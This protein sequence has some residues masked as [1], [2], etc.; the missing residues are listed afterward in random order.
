MKRT[1]VRNRIFIVLT[2]TVLVCLYMIFAATAGF[3]EPSRFTLT[4]AVYPTTLTA[5]S[6]FEVSGTLTG[7]NTITRVEVGVVNKVT[8]NY[9][10]GMYFN[11]TGINSRTYTLEEANRALKFGSLSAGT[12]Y[13]RITAYDGNG[14]QQVLNKEFSVIAGKQGWYKENGNWRYYR[15]DG[16][17]AVNEWVSDSA[18]WCWM[19]GNGYWTQ[20]NKWVLANGDWYYLR[21]GYRTENKWVKDSIGWCYVGSDGKLVRNGWAPDSVGWCW[22][23]GSGYWKQGSEWFAVDGEWYYLRNGYRAENEWVKDSEDWCFAGSDG[24]LV[25]NGWA[26]DDHGWCWMN[27]SGHWASKSQWIIVGEH[28]YYI[29]QD[30]YRATNEWAQDSIGWMWMGADGRISG[31]GWLLV[32]GDWYFINADGYMAAEMWIKDSTGW[33]WLKDSGKVA[34][35]YW[36][37]YKGDWYYLNNS[38]HMAADE[39]AEDSVGWCWLGSDGK[40]VKNRL[41]ELSGRKYYLNA[42]GYWSAIYDFPESYRAA[43]IQLQTAHPNWIIY[44]DQTGV[45][46]GDLLTKEKVVGRNL[47]EPTSPA[48]YINPTY[49]G[50]NYD[51]RWKQASDAAIAYYLDPR[52]FLTDKGIYQ[53]L[54]QRSSVNPGTAAQVT[55]LVSSNSCFMNTTA[56]INAILKAGRNSGVNPAV[57]TAMVIGEQG[58][59]GTSSLISGTHET[60]PGIYNH[61]NV[62]AYTANGMSA[63]TRG[64]WWASGAGVGATSYG[65]PWNT[66]EKSLTGGAAHYKAGYIDNKQYTYYTKKFNVMNGTANVGDHQYMTNVEGAYTEGTLVRLAYTGDNNVLIFRIPVYNS[67]PAS[68]CPAP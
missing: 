51:G 62:G 38:G 63:V 7:E 29:N 36:V 21:N 23:D 3:A 59:K 43:L 13:F 66:I 19:N 58:W 57:L 34:K 50:N 6:S 17:M 56:Y 9:A 55:K 35:R 61:F 52:N 41:L 2:A 14:S 11:K 37:Q 42:S 28:W 26:E 12:Y 53:F 27:S 32:D 54:D 18:G 15:A 31:K 68:A 45:V 1:A 60:Y 46:W 5:G 33:C 44:Q 47:V 48:T 67:M 30:G 65:R 22:M 10:S 25:R 64:L 24:K 40:Q 4:G 20:G 16:T 39:W 8:G 49:A